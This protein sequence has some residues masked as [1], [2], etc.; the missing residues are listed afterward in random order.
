[1][2]VLPMRRLWL[3]MLGLAGAIVAGPALAGGAP[4]GLMNKTIT[5]SW[6]TSGTGKRADG[7]TVSFSNIN[8]RLVYVSSAGRP[9]LRMQVSGRKAARSG[10]LAPGEGGGS[11]GASVNFQGDK[12]VGTESFASGAR[13]YTAAFDPSFSSCSLSVIDAKASGAPI[14]RRGP[15]GVMYEISSVS[16]G[17]PSCSVQSGNAFAR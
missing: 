9:F 3:G 11:R 13:Q 7:T 16:T 8:T 2:D 17:S 14:Q 10:E 6:S 5:M 1:M 15:D 12:L 4:A